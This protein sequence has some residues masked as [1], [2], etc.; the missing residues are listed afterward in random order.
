MLRDMQTKGLTKWLK[1]P[2]FCP[3]HL[4]A[5]VFCILNREKKTDFAI[6]QNIY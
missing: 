4:S 1:S 6:W 3:K 2:A 5:T